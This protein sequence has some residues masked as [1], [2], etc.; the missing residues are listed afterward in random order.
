MN[1]TS[2][3]DD[4]GDGF[5]EYQC[6]AEVTGDITYCQTGPFNETANMNPDSINY[7]GMCSIKKWSYHPD[8]NREKE[9][10]LYFVSKD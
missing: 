6:K 4:F 2:L 3:C 5:Y 8:F 1:N 10:C 9:L 7:C